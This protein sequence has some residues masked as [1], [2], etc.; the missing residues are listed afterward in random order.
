[1]LDGDLRAR[2]RNIE[3]PSKLFVKK[4]SLVLKKLRNVGAKL[5]SQQKPI[6][7]QFSQILESQ[8]GGAVIYNHGKIIRTLKTAGPVVGDKN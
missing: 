8:G 7:L 4:K 5:T 1:M 6:S 3:F 2:K